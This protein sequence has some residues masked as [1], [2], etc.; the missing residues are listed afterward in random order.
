[1]VGAARKLSAVV[2]GADGRRRGAGAA[3]EG[4]QDAELEA[5]LSGPPRGAT[6]VGHRLRVYECIATNSHNRVIMPVK[7]KLIVSCRIGTQM[8]ECISYITR[9]PKQN[10]PHMQ[11]ICLRIVSNH[12]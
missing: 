4:L 11:N 3:G 1:M 6:T 2:K 5:A 9:V 8:Q 10:A 7:V 12:W